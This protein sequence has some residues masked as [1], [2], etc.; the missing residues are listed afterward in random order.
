MKTFLSKLILAVCLIVLGFL[1]FFPGYFFISKPKYKGRLSFAHLQGEVKIITDR[2]GVPHI[3]AENEA[4]VF[5]AC[6][7]IHAK[8]RMWQM[9][10]ARR[11]G[12]GRLSELYGEDLLERDKYARLMGL[13]DAALR[14]YEKMPADMK[15]FL[16]A[17]CRGVN[18]WLDS[19]KWK[20]PP[21]FAL[22]RYRPEPWSPMDSLIIKQVMDLLLSTDFPS[23][24]V[25]ANLI[26]RVGQERALQILEEDIV[27][28]SFQVEKASLSRL[29]D[30]VYPQ[31]SN[32]WILSGERTVTG[33]PL[34]ANDPHLEINV[35]PVWYE[36][37]LQC[38]S[39]NVIGVSLPGL[40][41]VIIGHN[42]DIAWG[43]SNSTVD[44]QDLYIEKFDETR[45]MYWEKDGWIPLLKKEEVIQVKG[46]KEPEKFEVWWTARGPV[47]SPHIIES[48]NPISLKWSIHEGGRVFES[49]YLLNKAKNWDDFSAALSLFDSPSQNFGY[50]DRNNNIGLYLGGGIPVRSE[51]SALFPFPS[52]RGG[53]DWRGFLEEEQK[54]NLY[55][56]G[57]G[58]IVA[59]NQN[60]LPEDYPFYVSRDWDAPFRAERIREL[61]LKT[62]KHSV[63]SFKSIQ[64]DVYSKKGE[65]FYPLIR[66]ISGAAGKLQQAL[67]ILQ[68]W[69]LQM[70]GGKAPALYDTFMNALPEEIFRD[71]LGDDFRSFDFFFRRKM[72]GT[73]RIL[74]DLDS[75][76]FDN[77][78]TPEPETRQDAIKNA[79]LRA[80][81][82][83]DWLYGSS[84]NW[85]W[86]KI[87]AVR[88]QHP[89]GR[90]FLF[91]FFNLDTQPSNGNAFTV[92]VNYVTPH[93]TTWS[94]SYRQI[95][96]LENWDNSI[97]V[98][99]SGQSGHYM[100]R[101]YDDQARLWLGEE[102]HPMVFS[103]EGIEKNAAGTLLLKPRK[104]KD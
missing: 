82:R 19:R 80:Y 49:F 94:A 100:S 72:A 85:D 16:A 3:F 65:L 41:W 53:G 87:N 25:R 5:F 70:D 14:D 81:N 102:Y 20:W 67:A 98:I 93:K 26:Y 43:L 31:Q 83:L 78:E 22:L 77:R 13:E 101:F 7:F 58:M 99:S 68:D 23:E 96:D 35:P 84:D 8:E 33:K 38:P 76:W 60:I 90:F 54:P 64:T 12:Y 6:G 88:Y 37:H 36:I 32:N 45:D 51:E 89:L 92:K 86:N 91:R 66:E 79:L 34:L 24:A 9:D 97:C 61:L 15:E 73:L 69:D 30:M 28:P 57:E 44:S 18:A 50:A 63:S 103:R 55:N 59:A 52:W 27:A 104:Q 21:E 74:S 11:A 95:I 42:N 75:P 48:E 29:L 40:P 17:Y 71:E 10:M 4:D 1:L 46:R 47:I 62:E 56:P 39:L 2:W